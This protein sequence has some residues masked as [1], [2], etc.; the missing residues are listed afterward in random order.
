MNSSDYPTAWLDLSLVG[1]SDLFTTYVPVGL[2]ASIA[3]GDLV[4]VADDTVEPRLFRVTEVLDD[5]LFATYELAE[6]VYA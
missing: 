2:R 6:P 4:W 3:E 5:G 1:N